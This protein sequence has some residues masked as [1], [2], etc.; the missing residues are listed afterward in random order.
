MELYVSYKDLLWGMTFTE[1]MLEEICTA[2]NGKPEVE[3]D[4]N[5]IS[6]KAPYRRLPILDAIK[7]KTGFDCDGKTETVNFT[8]NKKPVISDLTTQNK[9]KGDAIQVSF[10]H[11]N[12]AN[13]CNWEIVESGVTGSKAFTHDSPDGFPIATSAMDP[14]T[15]TLRVWVS[16]STTTCTSEY[17]EKTFTVYPIPELDVKDTTAI[18]P[19]TTIG[20]RYT[21]TDAAGGTYTYTLN[22]P[23]IDPSDP[24][25]GNGSAANGGLIPVGTNGLNPGVYAL[26]VTVTSTNGCTKTDD[27]TI[28]IYDPTEITIDEPV[29]VDVCKGSTDPIEVNIHTTYADKYSYEVVVK[30]TTTHPAD[31]YEGSATFTNKDDEPVDNTISIDISNWAAAKYT[32]TVKAEN[33]VTHAEKTKS[34]DF[35]IYAIPTVTLSTIPD[36][37][38]EEVTTSHAICQEKRNSPVTNKPLT[39]EI[40]FFLRAD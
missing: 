17:A 37:I 7:E 31:N 40:W 6:F 25:T 10:N 20:V 14:G 36:S 19:Q 8:I 39:V 12:V 5:I 22:G 28:T 11:D 26:S 16:N 18:Y 2:V 1:N 24:R 4:G 9:C 32:I 35:E 21:A 30:G 29:S 27:A 33:T 38:C 13:G 34:A 23:G 15:Y 3:I